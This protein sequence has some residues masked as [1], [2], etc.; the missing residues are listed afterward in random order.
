MSVTGHQG[1]KQAHG[2]RSGHEAPIL[3]KRTASSVI[4]RAI[5]RPTPSAPVARVDGAPGRASD[6]PAIRSPNWSATR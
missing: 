1:S 4:V 6:E 2:G 3:S 5:A